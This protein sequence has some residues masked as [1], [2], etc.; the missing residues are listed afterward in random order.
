M[1]QKPVAIL[2]LC[3]TRSRIDG[4]RIIQAEAEDSGSRLRA[5]LI[6]NIPQPDKFKSATITLREYLTTLRLEYWTEHPI[7]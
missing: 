2:I 3:T 4:M 6:S 5:N 1:H 7:Y